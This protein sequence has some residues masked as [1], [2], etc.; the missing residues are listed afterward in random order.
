VLGPA[1]T[2]EI[3]FTARRY[4]AD[5]AL[6]VGLLNRV[7]PKAELDAEVRRLAET[8]AT[9]APLTVR[10]VKLAAREAQRDPLERD[11]DAVQAAIAACFDSEDYREGVKAFL[12]KRTPRFQGR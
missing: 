2:K 10:A 9:N 1:V 5:E 3:F 7:F 11:T 12:E 8:I 4:Q 6:Q